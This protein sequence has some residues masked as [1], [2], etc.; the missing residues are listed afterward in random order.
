MMNFEF[1][2]M[3]EK[4]LEQ[5]LLTETSSHITP[6]KANNFLDCIASNYWNYVFVDSGAMY[7]AITL[8]FLRNHIDWN[9][10]LAVHEALQ[11]I[12]LDFEYNDVKGTSDIFLFAVH[13]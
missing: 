13:K 5:V 12:T 3:Q 11:N 2:I 10:E 8:Y 7:R 4:D 1:K 6:W 9:N